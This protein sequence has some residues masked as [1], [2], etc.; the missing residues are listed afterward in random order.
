MRIRQLS[1]SLKYLV[2]LPLIAL[3]IWSG[4][5]SYLR[6]RTE[7][8]IRTRHYPGWLLEIVHGVGLSDG[9]KPPAG[10]FFF[11]FIVRNGRPEGSRML[12]FCYL[13]MLQLEHRIYL[14]RNHSWREALF[15]PYRW[16]LLLTFGWVLTALALP[17]AGLIRGQKG[18]GIQNLPLE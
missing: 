4:S 10:A 13:G 1:P 15:F 14:F 17:A 12:C 8:A 9:N 3:L 2:W 16:P 6:W 7:T 18:T 5:Y 11:A